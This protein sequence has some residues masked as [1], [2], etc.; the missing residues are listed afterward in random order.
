MGSRSSYIRNLIGDGASFLARGVYRKDW[1]RLESI[2][3]GI[4][5]G[6][7]QYCLNLIGWSRN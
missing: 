7:Q 1:S 3:T 4:Y 6:D 5:K 2:P